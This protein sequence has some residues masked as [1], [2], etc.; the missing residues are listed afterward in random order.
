MSVPASKIFFKGVTDEQVRA[1]MDREILAHVDPSLPLYRFEYSRI[2]ARLMGKSTQLE[3]KNAWKAE[4]LK[5]QIRELKQWIY[6]LVELG[7]IKFDQAV[8]RRK[9]DLAKFYKSKMERGVCHCLSR[10][11][12]AEENLRAFLTIR[13]KGSEEE[14]INKKLQ[15]LK[16]EIDDRFESCINSFKIRLHAK[17]NQLKLYEP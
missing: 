11:D 2:K 9:S 16:R 8:G 5:S 1:N 15:I 17:E 3:E 10:S 12:F 14:F 13:Y 6:E 7:Q 4:N